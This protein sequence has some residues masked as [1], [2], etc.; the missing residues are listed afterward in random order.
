LKYIF[1]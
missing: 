1:T